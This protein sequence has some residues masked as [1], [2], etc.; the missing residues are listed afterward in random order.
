MVMFTLLHLPLVMST[1][2][3][4]PLMEPVI[5]ALAGIGWARWSSGK[6][7][8]QKEPGHAAAVTA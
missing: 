5:L 3:R 4:I 2:L 7:K 1:R 8:I 6:V